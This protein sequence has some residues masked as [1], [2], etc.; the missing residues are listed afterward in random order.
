[1]S[2]GILR[3]VARGAGPALVLAALACNAI[4][5]VEDAELDPNALSS[6][7]G[8][9]SLCSEEC[10]YAGDGACDDYTLCDVGTDCTDCGTRVLVSEPT[11]VGRACSS[12]STCQSIYE[13]YCPPAGLCT[14]ECQTHTDCGCPSGTTNQDLAAGLC[15]VQCAGDGESDT[16]YCFRTCFANSQCDTGTICDLGPGGGICIPDDW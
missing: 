4:V 2:R 11:D 12:D 1:M 9:V 8:S 16:G 14:A 13:G 15:A 10:D 7:S 6:S 5:G 3:I